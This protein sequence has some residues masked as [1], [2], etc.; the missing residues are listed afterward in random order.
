MQN[1]RLILVISLL[2]ASNTL[3][4]FGADE[5]ESDAEAPVE[6]AIGFSDAVQ[7]KLKQL[8]ERTEKVSEDGYARDV[9]EPSSDE[10]A[11]ATR[12]VD[13]GKASEEKSLD[14]AAM[15]GL[16]KNGVGVEKSSSHNDES[17]LDTDAM[18]NFLKKN[19]K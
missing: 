8:R 18:L 4:S 13:A 19:D 2:A 16:L 1:K 7:K 3:V 11:D 14:T 9:S 15:L 5:K 17:L 6:G 10:T 12:A